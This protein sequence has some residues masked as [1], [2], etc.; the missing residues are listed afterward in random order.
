MT[1]EQSQA[2]VRLSMSLGLVAVRTQRS[3]DVFAE[4]QMAAM[5]ALSSRGPPMLVGELQRVVG[6]LP[7]QMSRIMN[8][9]ERRQCV[10]REINPDDRRKVNVSLAETGKAELAR[11]IAARGQRLLDAPDWQIG[12]VLDDLKS[13]GEILDTNQELAK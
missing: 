12:A 8:R 5:T 7:A 13:L 3:S 4:C 10:R 1:T 6:C 9:L 2:M 11:C